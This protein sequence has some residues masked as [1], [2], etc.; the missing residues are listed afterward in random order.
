M[1]F[2]VKSQEARPIKSGENL[3][4]ISLGLRVKRGVEVENGV[5][6]DRPPRSN[7]YITLSHSS[8]RAHE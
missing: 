5:G 1:D 3:A 6:L 2:D 7:L 4:Q 8:E